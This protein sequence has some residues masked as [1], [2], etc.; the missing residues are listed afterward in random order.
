[1]LWIYQF[2][3][4]L[5]TIWYLLFINLV[6]LP[7][8][9]LE[10]LSCERAQRKTI[11]LAKVQRLIA[12]LASP[13]LRPSFIS[14]SGQQSPF[15]L[16]P[17]QPQSFL[18]IWTFLDETLNRNNLKITLGVFRAQLHFHTPNI[19]GIWTKLG[20]S[21]EISTDPKLL[22]LIWEILVESRL[23]PPWQQWKFWN[24]SENWKDRKQ[25]LKT[26]KLKS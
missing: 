25:K 17:T 16:D 2:G 8:H 5:S 6:L 4:L 23:S 3:I 22:L 11:N 12:F 14:L 18:N 24:R 10:S 20:F 15:V 21:F 1:M 13:L 9:E 7:C 19:L 26:E